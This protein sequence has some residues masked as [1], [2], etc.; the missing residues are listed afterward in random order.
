MFMDLNGTFENVFSRESPPDNKHYFF[1]SKSLTAM[2][3][4]MVK[5]H[6]RGTSVL[7]FFF[8]LCRPFLDTIKCCDRLHSGHMTQIQT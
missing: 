7:A 4:S 5:V 6:S 3:T 1:A 8:D 2:L